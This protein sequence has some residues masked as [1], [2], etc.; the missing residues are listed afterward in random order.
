M[1]V[2]F[3]GCGNIAYFHADV[4]KA[5]DVNISA[6]SA[7]ENSP[8]IGPFSEKYDIRNQYT[9][10]QEMVE[11]EVLD[12]LWVV[13]SWD[14]MDKLLLPVIKLGLPTF[15]EKPVKFWSNWF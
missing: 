12:A 7:R 15:F 2:G 10:W 14:E 8:N 1:N 6:V 4:L 5:L 9:H 11:N 13:A 3:I